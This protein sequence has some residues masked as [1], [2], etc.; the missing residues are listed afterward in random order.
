MPTKRT[1]LN[2][3]RSPRIDSETLALFVELEAVPPRQRKGVE[4]RQRDRELHQ[5]L[6]LGSEWFCSVCSVLDGSRVPYYAAGSPQEDDW[7]RVRT[8]RLQL[9]AAAGMSSE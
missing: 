9:L 5:R 3:Q 8:T 2:R 6:G 7:R 4:F 1:P